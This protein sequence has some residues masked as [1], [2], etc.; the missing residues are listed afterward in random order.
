MHNQLKKRAKSKKQFVRHFFAHFFLTGLDSFYWSTFCVNSYF[1]WVQSCEEILKGN[2]KGKNHVKFAENI[3]FHW[4]V[5]SISTN[6]YNYNKTFKP[7]SEAKSTNTHILTKHDGKWYNTCIKHYS[8]NWIYNINTIFITS[9]W[10]QEWN[11]EWN[12]KLNMQTESNEFIER[13][14]KLEC[15]T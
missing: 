6:E 15:I 10:K 3:R 2:T 14:I 5:M 8:T 9:K 4:M 12:K 1:L 13:C 7:G 11:H